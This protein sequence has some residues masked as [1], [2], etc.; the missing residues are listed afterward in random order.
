MEQAPTEDVLF[1]VMARDG[2]KYVIYADG[3][4]DGFGE[5]TIIMNFHDALVDIA[6]ERDRRQRSA[7]VIS[8]NLLSPAISFTSARAGAEHATPEQPAII[9]AAIRA[10][11]GEK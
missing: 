7:N 6:V 9:V 3:N 2:R 8:S 10:A 11:P 5:A 1:M 4:I